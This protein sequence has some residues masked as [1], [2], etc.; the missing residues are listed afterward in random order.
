MAHT[1]KDDEWHYWRRHWGSDD[2]TWRPGR[3]WSPSWLSPPQ[4]CG[5]CER[6]PWPYRR[7]LGPIADSPWKADCRR[8]ERAKARNLMNRARAG[9][10]DWDELAIHYRR[11]YYW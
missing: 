11:P 4:S 6:A 9:H 10:V 2:C 8:E 1:D 3:G 7:I 5:I